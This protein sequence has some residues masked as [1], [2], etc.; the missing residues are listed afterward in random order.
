MLRVPLSHA[1][2][3]SRRYAGDDHP[4]LKA[5]VRT[6]EELRLILDFSSQPRDPAQ[7]AAI[8]EKLRAVLV[9][10]AEANRVTILAP[11]EPDRF[12]CPAS[13]TVLTRD[14]KSERW[15][16]EEPDGYGH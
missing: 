16:V 14:W 6:M 8:R 3:Y 7:R 11:D 15:P 2:S 12:E 13:N 1:R 4:A 5:V 10:F 9:A